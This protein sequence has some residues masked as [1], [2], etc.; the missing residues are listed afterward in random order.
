MEAFFNTP[1]NQ[2][3]FVANRCGS[4]FMASKQAKNK[5]WVQVKHSMKFIKLRHY[6]TTVKVIRNPFERWCSWFNDF[7]ENNYLKL[8]TIEDANNWIRKFKKRQPKDLHTQKQII[9]YN[10]KNLIPKTE[11]KYIRTENLKKFVSVDDSI[12]YS[13]IHPKLLLIPNEVFSYMFIA[14]KHIYQDDYNWI[15]TLKFEE[16]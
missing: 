14:I 7:S 1:K 10:Q 13:S 3:I 8:R 9:L 16:I 15:N 4:N 6:T 12:H 11:E 5:G 2:Y